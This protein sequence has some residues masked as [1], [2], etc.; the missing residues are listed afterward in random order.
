MPNEVLELTTMYSNPEKI[1]NKE[2]LTLEGIVQFY[3]NVKVND[4]KF[5]VLTDIYELL[6]CSMYNLYQ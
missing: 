6:I 5:D 4:W 2:N 1:L 3:I